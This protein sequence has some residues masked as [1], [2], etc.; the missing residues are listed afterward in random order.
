[1]RVCR[2]GSCALL[3]HC[4][5]MAVA[6]AVA[7]ARLSSLLLWLAPASRG[8]S[9]SSVKQEGLLLAPL[10][11]AADTLCAVLSAPPRGGAPALPAS[12]PHHVLSAAELLCFVLRTGRLARYAAYLIPI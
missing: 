5:P 10:T 9:H 12:L 2:R 3:A 11:H 8:A 6:R 4:L 1:M 7:L